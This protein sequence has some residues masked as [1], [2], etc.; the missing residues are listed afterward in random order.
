[1]FNLIK[2]EMLKRKKMFSILGVLFLVMQA[3][4]IYE[5]SIPSAIDINIMGKG[6]LL[7]FI[8][9]T[10]FIFSSLLNFSKDINSTDR[11]L[12]FMTPYSGFTII[13]SK[14]LTT[15]ILGTFLFCSTF[16]WYVVNAIYVDPRIKFRVTESLQNGAFI[17]AVKIFLLSFVSIGSFFA[18]VFLSIIITKTFLSKLKFKTL[19][20]IIVMSILSKIFNL[21]F[22]DNL[23]EISS[24]NMGISIVAI[25]CITTLMLWISGWLIDNKTDF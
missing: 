13:S 7:V 15:I 10:V 24:T 8:S 23:N 9:Y 1:M 19:I 12:V 14:F 5:T 16:L 11:S 2:F 3:F 4:I 22:W 17:S 20:V 18:L 25:V 21:I 6:F